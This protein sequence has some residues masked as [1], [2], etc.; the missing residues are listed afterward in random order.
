MNKKKPK[1]KTK[2]R[3]KLMGTLMLKHDSMK[4]LSKKTILEFKE[5]KL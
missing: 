2:W 1:P 3:Y 4:P 5:L